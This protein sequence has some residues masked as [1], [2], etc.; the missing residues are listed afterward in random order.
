MKEYRIKWQK[1]TVKEISDIV[2]YLC[3]EIDD[4][5]AAASVIDSIIAATETLADFPLAFPVFT[6]PY[7]TQKFVHRRLVVKNYVVIFRV[8]QRNRTVFI[9]HVIHARRNYMEML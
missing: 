1:S 8:N 2:C 3:D 6:T 7:L 9:E 4:P 5:Y